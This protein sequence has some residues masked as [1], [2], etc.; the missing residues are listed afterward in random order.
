MTTPAALSAYA[1]RA[2]TSSGP[3]ASGAPHGLRAL[4]PGRIA[5]P[6]NAGGA[7]HVDS[8]WWA[9]AALGL[10][11]P[12]ELREVAVEMRAHGLPGA[13]FA[14]VVDAH[15]DRRAPSAHVPGQTAAVRC[16]RR[17]CLPRDVSG[18]RT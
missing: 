10:G 5:R 14:G 2:T 8:L 18:G 16:G 11:E 6:A 7:V 1:A 3:G 15:G 4:R 9:D 17:R 13:R 12:L